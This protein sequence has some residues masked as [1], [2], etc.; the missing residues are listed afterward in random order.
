VIEE[1]TSGARYQQAIHDLAGR[2]QRPEEEV[3]DTALAD[4]KEMLPRIHPAGVGAFLRFARWLSRGYTP[5]VVPEELAQV[6]ALSQD[7]AVAFLF[8]HRS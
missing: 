5:D 6:R 2:L 1:I 4:L 3:R 8:G 7:H